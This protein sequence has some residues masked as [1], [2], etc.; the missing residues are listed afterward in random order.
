M[1]DSTSTMNQ[2]RRRF[3]VSSGGVIGAAALAGVL[4][5]TAQAADPPFV[6]PDDASAKALFYV[7]DATKSTNPKYKAG[8]DC[9]RCNFFT[10]SKTNPE[11]GACT[12]FP[13]KW[14]HTKGWCATYVKKP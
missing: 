11:A 9:A 4:A 1:S 13:G 14:V 5:R 7:E 12:I 8:D 2:S 3:V 6:S 10:V